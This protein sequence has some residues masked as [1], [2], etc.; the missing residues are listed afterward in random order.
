[1]IWKIEDGGGRNMKLCGFP[2]GAAEDGIN[3][4]G[5]VLKWIKTV[6]QHLGWVQED[7]ERLY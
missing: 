3:L 1:M 2:E 4:R 6:A 5:V 7:L